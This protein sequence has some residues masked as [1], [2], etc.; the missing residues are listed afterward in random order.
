MFYTPFLCVYTGILCIPFYL[1]LDFP[2][3]CLQYYRS[4]PP[5]TAFLLYFTDYYLPHPNLQ[6]SGAFYICV[7]SVFTTCAI[8]AL[9]YPATCTHRHCVQDFCSVLGCSMIPVPLVPITTTSF[10][11]PYLLTSLQFPPT[12]IL[13][14]QT[15]P[16]M[17]SLPPRSWSHLLPAFH[18]PQAFC[19]V[20]TWSHT[21][22]AVPARSH[23]YSHAF[24]RTYVLFYTVHVLV[25]SSLR[26]PLH[27]V[28]FYFLPFFPYLVHTCAYRFCYG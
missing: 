10:T 16:C 17:L 26:S 15:L 2:F 14:G 6:F 11:F 3:F 8:Q 24:P 22:A 20:H 12:C 18:T 21:P 27:T 7:F 9:L 28:P 13:T 19:T 23:T 5:T 4:P 25:Q 1:G